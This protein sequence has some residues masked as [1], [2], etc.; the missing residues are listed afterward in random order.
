MNWLG[1]GD[2]FP[3]TLAR[4]PAIAA[5]FDALYRSL[6]SQPHLSAQTL[7]ACRLRLAQLHRCDVEWQRSEVAIPSSKRDAL[8]DWHVDSQFPAAERACLAFTEVYAMDVQ[9]I[10]DELAQGVKDHYGDAGLV[11]LVE[12]LG[13]LDGRI[14]LC[15]LWDSPASGGP[16]PDPGA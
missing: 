3:S 15:L 16:R 13:I 4:L 2:D 11:C 10:T 7:E 12:A 9:A 6:W 5:S 1:T 14:R 8:K